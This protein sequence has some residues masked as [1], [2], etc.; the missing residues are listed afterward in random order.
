M[1]SEALNAEARERTKK[2]LRDGI[3]SADDVRDMVTALARETVDQIP[4]E[5][6]KLLSEQGTFLSDSRLTRWEQKIGHTLLQLANEAVLKAEQAVGD[7][8]AEEL[9]QYDLWNTTNV[10]GIYKFIW[11]LHE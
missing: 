4:F 8:L 5:Q 10:A 3:P 2:L 1:D 11:R 9:N 7:T 6:V